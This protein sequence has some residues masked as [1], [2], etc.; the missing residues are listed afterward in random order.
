MMDKYTV[1]TL[2]FTDGILDNCV[3]ATYVIHLEGNGRE[4]DMVNQLQKIHPTNTVHIVYNKGY[5]KCGEEYGIKTPSDDLIHAYLWAFEHYK[6][7]QKGN[8]NS[9]KR[10]LILEDDFIFTDKITQSEHRRKIEQI[11]N[12]ARDENFILRLGTIPMIT[13]PRTI[14]TYMGFS[15]GTHCVIYSEKCVES[16]LSNR[17]HITDW[18]VY[19]QLNLSTTQYIYNEPLCY[20][21][22][23]ETDNQNNWGNGNIIFWC[24]S[25]LIKFYL[26]LLQLDKQVEPGY[27]ISYKIGLLNGI[28]LLCLALYVIYYVFSKV[29]K[30]NPF[31]KYRLKTWFPFSSLR[32][33]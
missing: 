29:A 7:S 13:I 1:K 3:D 14:N 32:V 16:T 22:F 17:E 10:V 27:S 20:Q 30:S 25:L 33:R 28:I 5:R 31:R 24:V 21:L 19:Y 4:P 2:R 11:L 15:C 23:P 26:R 8:G 9:K 6:L 18:D 12:N